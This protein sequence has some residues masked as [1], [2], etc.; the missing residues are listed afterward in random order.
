MPEKTMNGKLT[1]FKCQSCGLLH[2]EERKCDRCGYLFFNKVKISRQQ[3]CELFHHVSYQW[4]GKKLS[5]QQ[6][7]CIEVYTY[8]CDRCGETC[9]GRNDHSDGCHFHSQC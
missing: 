1:A 9:T 2:K 4:D 7:C 3:Y 5:S 6:N 8:K